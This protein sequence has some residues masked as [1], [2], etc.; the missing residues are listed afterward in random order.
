MDIFSGFGYSSESI[1]TVLWISSESHPK[2][3]IADNFSQFEKLYFISYCLVS[4]AEMPELSTLSLSLRVNSKWS[5]K[6]R[7]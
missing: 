3:N 2:T 1:K 5:V 6:Q 7:K 4:H